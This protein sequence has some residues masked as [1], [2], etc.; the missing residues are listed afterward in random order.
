MTCEAPWPLP[1]VPAKWM[2]ALHLIVQRESEVTL[3]NAESPHKRGFY[4]ESRCFLAIQARVASPVTLNALQSPVLGGLPPRI[5]DDP[6][7]APCA[8]M[9]GA[10]EL[11]AF[12]GRA[13]IPCTLR[14]S[15]GSTL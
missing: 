11:H 7:I 2:S 13:H 3:T 9:R 5:T 4:G 8:W 12:A 14:L 1:V 6:L 10:L 15:Q